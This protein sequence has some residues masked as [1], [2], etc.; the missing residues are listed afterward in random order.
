MST[1]LFRFS[2]FF[3]SLLIVMYARVTRALTRPAGRGDLGTAG[4]EAKRFVLVDDNALIDLH[5]RNGV[6]PMVVAMVVLQRKR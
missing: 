1:L 6:A 3:F 5:S 4:S 2:L